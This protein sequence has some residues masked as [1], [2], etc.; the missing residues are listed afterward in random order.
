MSYSNDQSDKTVFFGTLSFHPIVM[1]KWPW[2]EPSE[3][4]NQ[5]R[6]LSTVK[7]ALGEVYTHV[8]SSILHRTGCFHTITNTTNQQFLSVFDSKSTTLCHSLICITLIDGEF[9]SLKDTI[10]G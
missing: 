6:L 5:N 9:E 2:S 4:V 1:P 3:T 7:N 10:I 8:G